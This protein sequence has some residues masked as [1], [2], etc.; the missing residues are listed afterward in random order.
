MEIMNNLKDL[1]FK[2][3]LGQEFKVFRYHKKES[4]KY[5][6]PVYVIGSPAGI[7]KIRKSTL[8][9][10]INEPSTYA[11][12]GRVRRRANDVDYGVNNIHT[13]VGEYIKLSEVYKFRQNNTRFHFGNFVYN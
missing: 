7:L 11:I 6:E 4:E 9:K 5:G 8:L 3:A 1:E 13:C 10:V 2:D 12:V